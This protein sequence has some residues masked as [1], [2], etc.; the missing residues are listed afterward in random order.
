MCVILADVEV[1]TGSVSA[2]PDDFVPVTCTSGRV[3][4][5]AS[6][7][8]GSGT[9]SGVDKWPVACLLADGALT[10]TAN[11]ETAGAGVGHGSTLFYTLTT[12]RVVDLS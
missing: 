3:I 8:I 6:A 4:V 1:E 9:S 10:D 11:I 12:A 5:A 2:D 7:F